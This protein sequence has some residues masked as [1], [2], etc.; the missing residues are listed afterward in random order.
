MGLADRD[1]MRPGLAQML[2]GV[3]QLTVTLSVM[4]AATWAGVAGYDVLAGR[5]AEVGAPLPAPPAYV[6]P[7]ALQIS[8]TVTI[9]RRFTGQF[10]PAQ[11]A[12]LGFEEG[13]TLSQVLVREGDVV[14][15][16]APLARLDTRLLEAERRRLAAS[17]AVLAAEVELA[18]RTNAR[19]ERLLSEGHVTP[20]RVDETSLTLARLDA[21]LAEIDA[22]LIAFDVR[23]SK[24]EIVAPFAGRIGARHLDSGAVAGPGASVVTLLE[25][26]PA[27][28][29]V[30]L[31]PHLAA[32]LHPGD[33][34]EIETHTGRLPAT[35]AELSPELDGATRGQVAFF[36]LTPGTVVPPA[37]SSGD[38]ILRE[39][40][41]EP[42]AWVP[43]AALR[44]GPRG[45]WTLLVVENDRVGVEAV[46]ILHLEGAQAYIRGSFIDGALYLPSGTH[47]VVPGE[48]VML[49]E[50]T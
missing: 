10:E 31:D 44:P 16:G 15:A 3:T 42:G 11:E 28:F 39:T 13:G 18:R 25:D 19:Q 14:A 46:E 9:T 48:A 50:R 27:R 1:N 40:R 22:K 21:A 6:S 12:A 37:R 32:G 29:R 36:D 5:A 34:V 20:Q 23:L 33:A 4:G 2:R 41:P 30:A 38:V 35:L 17:R 45:T 49:A 43:V 8:G 26:A 47:R 7:E 24:T